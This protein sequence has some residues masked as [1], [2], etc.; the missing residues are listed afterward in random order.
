MPNLIQRLR[1]TRSASREK[2]AF[3]LAAVAGAVALF[4]VSAGVGLRGEDAAFVAPIIE[5]RRHLDASYVRQV[6]EDA[7]QRAAMGG[8][9]ALLNRGLND[10]FSAYI[11]PEDERAFEASVERTNVGIGVQLDND[12]LD[13]RRPP[14]IF[15]VIKNGPA[16][17][18]GVR[19]G[20]RITQVDGEPAEGVERE[21]L[22]GRIMG[23]LGT[24]VALTLERDDAEPRE[25]AVRRDV[26]AS[27]TVLPM[28]YNDDGSPD[29][30]I[31]DDRR[32]ALLKIPQFTLDTAPRFF[33]VT[34]KL[35]ENGLR[36][37]VIDLRDD[38]GGRL[39]A[40]RDLLDVLLPA[41]T[42]LYTTEGL[43]DPRRTV[44]AN[45]EVDWTDFELVVMVNAN[46]A[47]A[48]ELMAGSLQYHN[49]ASIVGQRTFGKASVQRSLDLVSGGQLKLTIAH[50]ALPDGRVLH[51]EPGAEVW[52]V[53]PDVAVEKPEPTTRP[54]AAETE[55]RVAV[56]TLIFLIEAGGE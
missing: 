48:S 8:M 18:A 41:G 12:D 47:S 32:L 29:F 4:D 38:G 19:A 45:G 14:R 11:P 6:P 27:P 51:R 46:T 10:P 3:G 26:Y 30:W 55:L 36:G 50:Y 34:Q 25:V 44:V 53:E 7:L 15:N 54:D 56:E 21:E 49:R 52:G 16:D 35:R 31:D 42:P 9:F 28:R 1:Q 43:R 20:D 40:A 22:R 24:K 5:T 39:D 37:M 2:L 13:A 23:E 17:Q 33:D